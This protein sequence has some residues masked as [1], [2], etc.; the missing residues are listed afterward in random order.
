VDPKGPRCWGWVEWERRTEIPNLGRKV[1]QK[2]Y[3]RSAGEGDVDNADLG[4]ELCRTP[5]S[6][7][8]RVRVV[9]ASWSANGHACSRSGA[10][11]SRGKKHSAAF[12]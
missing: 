10:G 6:A 2:E 1:T 12:H 9:L 7:R 11:E 8:A 4:L 3:P 5:E